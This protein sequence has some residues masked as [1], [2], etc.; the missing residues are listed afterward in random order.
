MSDSD[1]SR[2]TA[3]ILVGGGMRSA[4]SAGFL[5]ALGTTLNIKEPDIIVAAS[6]SAGGSSYFV[7]KQYEGEKNVW[8]KLLST[9]KYISLLRFWKIIDVDYLIDTVLRKEEPLDIHAIRRARTNLFIVVTKVETGSPEF[10]CMNESGKPFELLRATKAHPLFYRKGVTIDGK[11]YLDGAFGITPQTLVDFAI[12]KGVERI[13]FV[14]DAK[15]KNR[16]A[17]RLLRF[18]ARFAPRYVRATLSRYP[19][20]APPPTTPANVRL[21]YIP[22]GRLPAGRI[23]RNRARLT[24]CFELGERDALARSEE[25]RTLLAWPS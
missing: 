25:L 20:T 21:I 18:V 13:L 3:I 5:Y 6:G 2:K 12:S 9:R 15:E 7:A 24:R 14:S 4:Y 17:A 22:S 23:T 1:K 19:D 8:T 10:Y 11:Q 16:T